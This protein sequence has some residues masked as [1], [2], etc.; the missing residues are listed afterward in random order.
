MG[1]INHVVLVGNLTRDA[2]LKYTNS[3]LAIAHFTLA[4]NR[5]VKK[6]EGW[7]DEPGFFDC[8]LMGKS[9]EA[10]QQYLVKG[11]QVAIQGELRQDRWEQDGQRRSKVV[12]H[13]WNLQLLGGRA[14]ERAS[15]RAGERAGGP[16]GPGGSARAE[17]G[18]D[19]GERPVQDAPSADDFDDDI[20]F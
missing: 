11:K 6:D 17:R 9:A 7:Q 14:S 8:D 5:R 3:G 15:E 16:G 20:P 10:V 13:V 2:E 19:Q 4:V 1:S 18:D 12:I